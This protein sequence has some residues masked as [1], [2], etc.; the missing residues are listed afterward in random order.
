MVEMP[1]TGMRVLDLTQLIPGPFCS[2]LLADLGADVIKIEPPGGEPHRL[3]G[4]RTD[5]V[6]HPSFL[7]LNRNKRGMV[8]DLKL[9]EGLEVFDA[10]LDT[11]DVVVENFRPGVSRALHV[12]YERLSTIRAGLIYGTVTG[13]GEGG[14][15]SERPA[16]DLIAQAMSGLMSVT[17]EQGQDPVKVGVPITDLMAGVLC[18]LG[19][20]SAHARRLQGGE[21]GRV[22]TSLFEAGVAFAV[23]ESGDYWTT[24]RVP[25]PLGSAHRVVAPHQALR[26]RDGHVVIG[27]GLQKHFERLC[28]L[29]GRLDLLADPRFVEGSARLENKDALGVELESRLAEA[30]TAEWVERLLGAGVPA[31]PLLDYG[32]VLE[33]EHTHALGLVREIDDPVGGP[34]KVLG[35]PLRVSG[36][37]I[38]MR[39]PP[40]LGEHTN[41]VLAQIGIEPERA[42]HLRGIGAVG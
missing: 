30:P 41:E 37:D 9:R 7:T 29:L 31:G 25:E 14:P 38:A 28:A 17:G 1:L 13:F 27:A 12:D 4:E 16:F 35:P 23:H 22:T 34:I 10:L 40:R 21:G 36:A 32:Q 26:T 5:C 2:M 42:S 11:A 6:D 8:I 24:G 19:I 33:D 3:C 39:R 18:A 20:S 15:Y